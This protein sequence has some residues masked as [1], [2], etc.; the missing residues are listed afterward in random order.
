MRTNIVLEE[1]LINQAI[2]V[3]GLRTKRAAVEAGLRL[4]IQTYS[5][6]GIRSLRGK[7]DWEG[8]LGKNR[9]GRVA[10]NR[11]PYKP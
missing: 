5:Q 8:D 2:R 7:V 1:T 11:S 4:L 10:E 9:V 3:T 6:S